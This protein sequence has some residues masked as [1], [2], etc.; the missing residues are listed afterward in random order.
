MFA[1]TR[2]QSWPFAAVSGQNWVHL[3]SRWCGKMT[4]KTL[5]KHKTT[6]NHSSIGILNI[7]S[8][9]RFH[10]GSKSS[11]QSWWS[12]FEDFNAIASVCDNIFYFPSA[13]SPVVPVLCTHRK[14]P[15]PVE[16]TTA[17]KFLFF[18]EKID[19]EVWG[20]FLSR[21]T[22]LRLEWSVVWGP[23][24]PLPDGPMDV[25]D[26]AIIILWKVW[27][28]VSSTRKYEAGGFKW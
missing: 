17:L 19:F 12:A 7:D 4:E 27:A 2:T 6:T 10:R 9:L 1:Q 21:P 20:A 25:D 8:M 13:S 15:Y 18:V 26:D 16:I 14:N 5:T 22:P 28:F 24:L 23:F 3:E 11:S